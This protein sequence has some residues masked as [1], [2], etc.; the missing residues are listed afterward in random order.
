M[1]DWL[2]E[3]LQ[4]QRELPEKVPN[5]KRVRF[6]VTSRGVFTYNCV[7]YAAKDETKPW[8]PI[9]PQKTAR[10]YYWPEDLPRKATVPNFMRAFEKLGYEECATGDHEEGYEKVALYVD[11]DNKPKHMAR[12][13]GDG[14]WAS[15]LGD[16][17]DIRHHTLEAV[18]T[19]EYG[20]AKYFMRKPLEGREE[21][22]NEQASERQETDAG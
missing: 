14:I 3:K 17:Q 20:T 4:A 2:Q 12:E 1:L 22:I 10:Y 7:A 13:L 18:E 8:W 21:G 11:E 9:K 15:K 19:D 5:L 6:E 16:F